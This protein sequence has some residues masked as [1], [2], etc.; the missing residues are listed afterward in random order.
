VLG[1]K[2]LAYDNNE[3]IVFLIRSSGDN[4][5]HNFELFTIIR[6]HLIKYSCVKRL[7]N[8]FEKSNKNVLGN[9]II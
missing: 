1:L 8:N 7:N 5:E 9:C 3:I 2:K 6:T 4:M